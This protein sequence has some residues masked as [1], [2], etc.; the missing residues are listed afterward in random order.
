[1]VYAIAYDLTE[2]NDTSANYATLIDAIKATFAGWCHIEQSVWLVSSSYKASEI[3][4]SLK[5]YMH[6]KDV[7]FVARLEGS[8]ASWN[9][10]DKRNDWLQSADF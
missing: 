6:D 5:R 7:L 2:P 1:M 10:G 8:W 9:F 4:E 3:R